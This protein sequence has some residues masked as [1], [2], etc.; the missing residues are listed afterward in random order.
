VHNFVPRSRTWYFERTRRTRDP[1]D[2]GVNLSCVI[3]SEEMETEILIR[4]KE[5]SSC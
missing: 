3:E 1:C 2:E 5:F 4:R